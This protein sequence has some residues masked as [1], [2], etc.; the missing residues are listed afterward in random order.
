MTSHVITVTTSRKRWLIVL[1]IILVP[2]II[3]NF[4]YTSDIHDE[5]LLQNSIAE[6]QIKLEHLHSKYVTSQEEIQLLSYQLVQMAE[7]APLIPDVQIF[8]N[9][10]NYNITNIKLP[11]IY[12]FLPHLLNDPNS[13]RPAFIHSKGRSGVSIVLGI[14]TVKRAVQSYLMSTLKNLLSR[15]N[16]I[17][18]A[19]TLI[20][21]FIAEV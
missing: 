16:S 3:L 18:T 11:S 9:N 6:L 14:P 13:L 12:N 7:G 5:S 8:I 2:C 21:V 15:M 10:S 19:D 1:F 4:S 17:E 20:V